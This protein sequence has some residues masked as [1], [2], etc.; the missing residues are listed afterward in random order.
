MYLYIRIYSCCECHVIVVIRIVGE[1]KGGHQQ[2]WYHMSQY[3][4]TD[5]Y[6]ACTSHI[7]HFDAWFVM[8]VKGIVKP[9]LQHVQ[10][11]FC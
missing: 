1:P 3:N 6:M 7:H 10:L 5:M 4:M 11:A 9:Q 2:Q 8:K